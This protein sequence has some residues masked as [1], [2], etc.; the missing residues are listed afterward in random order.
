MWERTG[1]SH[2]F[3]RKVSGHLSVGSVPA[4]TIKVRANITQALALFPGF[5]QGT[6]HQLTNL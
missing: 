3:R 2:Y 4:I 1:M 5:I 6:L